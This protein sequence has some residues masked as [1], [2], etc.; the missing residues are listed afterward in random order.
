MKLSFTQSPLLNSPQGFRCVAYRLAASAIICGLLAACGGGGGGG[1]GTPTPGVSSSSSSAIAW[2]A[3]VF[4]PK[5][6]FANKCAVPR[7]G[8]DPSTKQAFVDTKGSALDEK[9]FLRSWSNETYL[10]YSEI[11]DSN[12]ANA[13]SIANY[14]TL[15]KTSAKTASGNNKDNFHFTYESSEWYDLSVTG[16][17]AG[18]GVE[19]SFIANSPPRSLV[20][21][22]T[23]PGSP[24]DQP[25]LKR[26]AK[27]IKVDD[28]DFVNAGDKTSVDKINAGLFPQ[29]LNE[30]HTIEVLNVGSTTT[31]KIILTSA[32]VVKTPVQNVKTIDTANGKVG[33]FLFNDHLKTAER[34]LYD[35]I[36]T[37]STQGISDLVLDVRYNGG[38]Y[39]YIASELAFMI[40]GNN[41]KPGAFFEKTMFNDKHTTLGLFG[42]TITPTPFY[43]GATPDIGG[44]LPSLNLKRV[45]VITS[46]DTCSASEAIINGLRGVDVEVIQIGTK[47]CGKP[48]GF[49]PEDN[50]GTTYFSIQFKGVNNKGFG[51]YS[52]GFVP[53]TPDK[54]NGLDLVKGCTLGDDLTHALGDVA[55]KNLATALQYRQNNSCILASSVQSGVKLQKL[56]VATDL[57][58]VTGTLNK[59]PGLTNRIMK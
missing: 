14:F 56:S 53:T 19:F 58:D 32:S 40:A 9:N 34:G 22:Y 16:I 18:Y 26:G 4:K 45:F 42:E 54:D 12:P 20:V 24:A 11:P 30:V 57:S 38:G 41:I 13:S 47:T 15:L 33:Y 35:A 59:A 2:Q 39:L 50:C 37:L 5:E 48:Y 49:Y 31:D 21:A 8:I 52:D 6:D 43:S 29:A 36:N 1:G 55:E 7:T 10:W 25:K 46:G 3:G 28:V 44:A 23:E 17:S 51:E 27:I